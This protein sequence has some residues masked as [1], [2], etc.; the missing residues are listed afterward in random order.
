MEFKCSNCNQALPSHI[1]PY[2]LMCCL[3]V[4]CTSCLRDECLTC[5]ESKPEVTRLDPSKLPVLSSLICAQDD[6]RKSM[7]D[8]CDREFAT[9]HCETC[10]TSLCTQCCEVIHSRGVYRLHNLVE[11]AEVSHSLELDFC[12]E[13][14]LPYEYHT[15]SV[16]C[17]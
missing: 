11:M 5:G 10:R 14:N 9:R 7:C 4:S 6:A 3:A 16:V 12:Q 17:G 13:H 8:R 15:N 2:L 1:S